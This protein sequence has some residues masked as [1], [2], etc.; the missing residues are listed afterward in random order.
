MLSILPHVS[1]KSTAFFVHFTRPFSRIRCCPARAEPTTN[2]GK[3]RT[4]VESVAKPVTLSTLST[5][6][7]SLPAYAEAGKLFDFNLT[8][9]IMAGQFLLL[10]YF[11]E[12]TWFT[13]VGDLLDK[14]DK[15]IRDQLANVSDKT[16]EIER[17]EKEAAE[18]LRKARA[19][20]QAAINKA[21]RETEAANAEKY[22]VAKAAVDKE[23]ANAFAELEQEKEAAV[24][25]LQPEV[26]ALSEEII[27][28]ILPAGVA[29]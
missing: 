19:D 11:L 23:I 1:V 16:Q 21:R 22:A 18:I 24:N 12:K 29:I 27:K 26:E 17:L 25:N 10:M 3:W 14:R 5:L 7:L 6:V 9:P 2:E 28:R 8:L 13:P 20:A 4:A 15:L